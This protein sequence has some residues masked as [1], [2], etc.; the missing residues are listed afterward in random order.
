MNGRRNSLES[1]IFCHH[2]QDSQKAVEGRRGG[3]REGEGRDS[4]ER[5]SDTQREGILYHQERELGHSPLRIPLP[6]KPRS[7]RMSKL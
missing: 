6:A 5:D 2:Y 1:P 3:R 4:I 7:S